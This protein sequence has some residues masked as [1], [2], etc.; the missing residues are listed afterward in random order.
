M[1][2]TKFYS[3]YQLFYYGYVIGTLLKTLN[4]VMFCCFF[5]G[6]GEITWHKCNSL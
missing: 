2:S 4:M 5:F 6:G 1:F 3:E